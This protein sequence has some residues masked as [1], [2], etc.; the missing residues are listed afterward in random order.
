MK[1][2]LTVEAT[3]RLIEYE[4]FQSANR[5]SKKATY[6]AAGALGVSAF[7]AIVSIIFSVYFFNKQLD[8]P[9]KI[10]QDQFDKIIQL[11]FDASKIEQSIEEIVELQKLQQKMLESKVE[12]IKPNN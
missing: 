7:L 9:T 8:S 2:S 3:F 6:W 4:E 12:P 1:F 11:Q 10:E 5:S